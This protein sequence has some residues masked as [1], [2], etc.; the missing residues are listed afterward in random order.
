[1]YQ[2]EAGRGNDALEIAALRARIS[3]AQAGGG[4]AI[5]QL[6]HEDVDAAKHEVEWLKKHPDALSKQLRQQAAA[7][8][9]VEKAR[10]LAQIAQYRR[11]L[12]VLLHSSPADLDDEAVIE[13]LRS[14]R[15]H[16]EPLLS[17]PP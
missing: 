2:G 5:V 7:A 14:L 15:P 1:M 6:W 10:D 11:S 17:L 13:V 4:D 3:R 12:R 16:R 9:R 8:K